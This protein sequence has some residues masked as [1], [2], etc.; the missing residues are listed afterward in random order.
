MSFAHRTLAIFIT[1]PIFA[2]GA[3]E[4]KP[5]ETSTKEKTDAASKKDRDAAKPQFVAPGSWLGGKFTHRND[6]TNVKKMEES[7]DRLSKFGDGATGLTKRL[8]DNSQAYNALSEALDDLRV[9]VLDGEFASEFSTNSW[10]WLRAGLYE[11]LGLDRQTTTE[12]F[13]ARLAARMSFLET[14]VLAYKAL[15]SANTLLATI[16]THQQKKGAETIA[17]T[18]V[19]PVKAKEELSLEEKKQEAADKKEKENEKAVAEAHDE[20]SKFSLLTAVT[21]AESIEQAWRTSV[22]ATKGLTNLPSQFEELI[23][24]IDAR[25]DMQGASLLVASVGTG[26]DDSSMSALSNQVANLR[27]QVISNFAKVFC[28]RSNEVAE[29]KIT[30]AKEALR[31]PGET[32]STTEKQSDKKLQE[33]T[34]AQGARL[35]QLQKSL[36]QFSNECRQVFIDIIPATVDVCKWW[37]NYRTNKTLPALVSVREGYFYD[38]RAKASKSRSEG[39]VGPAAAPSKD[40][41]LQRTKE[42]FKLRGD[43]LGFGPAMAPS[44][45]TE[46]LARLVADARKEVE[47]SKTNFTYSVTNLAALVESVQNAASSL[48]GSSKE[49]KVV[50]D[51]LG[52]AKTNVSGAVLNILTSS[53]LFGPDIRTKF[54]KPLIESDKLKPHLEFIQKTLNDAQA[55]SE[56]QASLLKNLLNE[57]AGI[58]AQMRQEDL[59]HLQ[60]LSVVAL[61][62]AR[63]WIRLAS[64]HQ[65]YK[66]EFD[67]NNANRRLFAIAE[68]AL[69]RGLPP[70]TAPV[71]PMAQVNPDFL[72]LPTLRLLAFDA[73]WVRN[74]E[75]TNHPSG[76]SYLVRQKRTATAVEL[77]QG[78]FLMKTYNQRSGQDNARLLRRE[79]D[80]HKI[81]LHAIWSRANESHIRLWLNDQLAFHKTG[82]TQED[83]EG[84]LRAI[85]AGFVGWI[86]VKQ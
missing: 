63:R 76:W 73:Q 17:K 5:D 11:N 32:A 78:H 56:S 67:G 50:T 1:I 22:Q 59:R 7:I 45:N 83:V 27:Y 64:L 71:P 38:T 54:S 51:A 9:R 41:E 30:K 75:P 81:Q 19:P 84:L 35:E 77:I 23:Q 20:L 28:G 31:N 62:E 86:G 47:G 40:D 29:A 82:W 49:L 12:V 55:Y 6:P 68:P 80:E 13:E 66:G 57:L 46:Q 25:N 70:P 44:L 21:F 3:P 85:Q 24:Q 53:N 65:R 18:N 37:E 10:A 48:S 2:L 72:I 43:K 16:A 8:Q 4:P 52:T 34:K 15:I 42:A 26:L 33:A 60:S 61:Q 79:I 69:P 36:A 14:S 58:K 74:W 39:G